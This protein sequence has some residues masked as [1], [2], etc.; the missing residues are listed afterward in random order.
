MT[1][2]TSRTSERVTLWQMLMLFLSVYVLAAVFTETAFQLPDETAKLLRDVDTAVCVVFIADFLYHLVA[3]DS[4]WTYL[5]W[6]WVDLVSSIPYLPALRWGRAVRALRILRILRAVRSTR[7][8]IRVLFE[9]R[10]KGVLT[11]VA[12]MCF[13]LVVFS[14]VAMLNFET[15]AESN[16]RTAGDALWWA[17]ATVT[18][19]GC[20]D[21]F[22]VTLAGR[23]I[24]LVLMV[25]GVCLFGTVT[26][27]I[28]SVFL[29]SQQKKE[30]TLTHRVLAEVT[31][32][33][34][35][36]DERTDEQP[37]S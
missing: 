11:S 15:A 22:P 34:Q 16:I 1:H 13:V 3:A 20:G 7:V 27:Y 8:V 12:M 36:L 29:E 5:R 2:D 25:A 35:K 26:A 37:K 30:D 9:N 4:K 32:L 33:R 31:A 18:T 6:G 17:M 28:A 10:A 19:V 24:A 23:M 21:R 14:S